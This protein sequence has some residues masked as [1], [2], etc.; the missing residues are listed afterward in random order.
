MTPYPVTLGTI[1]HDAFE[2]FYLGE[3][4]EGVLKYIRNAFDKA[5]SE[6]GFADQEDLLI[7]KYMALGMWEFNPYKLEK[8]EFIAPEESFVVMLGEDVFTG[9]VDGRIKKNGTWWVRE[10]KTTAMNQR[11][12]EG[13]MQTSSQASGY[14]W[15]MRKLGH[16]VQGVMVDFLKRSLLHKAV[17]ETAHDFGRR[18]YLDYHDRPKYYFGR[19]WTYRS[20][21]DFQH[22][23]EDMLGL[24]EDIKRHTAD[25]KWY[26]NYDQCWNYNA[27]CPYKKI[28]YQEVPDS[29][30]LELYFKRRKT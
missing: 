19:I 17:D 11:Q 20:P 6:V 24:L 18:V 7:N 27:E 2:Q 15:A 9:R 25:N 8:F 29:L 14:I 4:D 30:T 12:F 13:R 10:V 3:S 21:V 16:D 1:V 28:C 22:Y 5:I 26:R 23:E